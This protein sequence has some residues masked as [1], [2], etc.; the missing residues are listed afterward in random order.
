M[1]SFLEKER[2][3]LVSVYKRMMAKAFQD[4]HINEDDLVLMI[5]RAVSEEHHAD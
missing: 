1:F 3:E 5:E 4:T 2:P